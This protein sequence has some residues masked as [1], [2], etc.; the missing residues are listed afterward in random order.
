M[1]KPFS[2]S[3]RLAS[4]EHL[5]LVEG[6][7]WSARKPED[8]LGCVVRAP[9]GWPSYRGLMPSDVFPD[10]NSS[11]M[12]LVEGVANTTDNKRRGR[13]MLDADREQAHAQMLIQSEGSFVV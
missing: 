9:R 5:Y 1:K 7:W 6:G 8:P 11:D 4:Q 2:K 10:A 12:S 13:P 3:I